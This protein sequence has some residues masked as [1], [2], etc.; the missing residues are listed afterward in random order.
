[1]L[2]IIGWPLFTSWFIKNSKINSEYEKDNRETILRACTKIR[3]AR[4]CSKNIDMILW[5]DE[6]IKYMVYNIQNYKSLTF[7]IYNMYMLK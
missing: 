2:Y 5:K 6:I 1:M 7:I 3:R 4:A